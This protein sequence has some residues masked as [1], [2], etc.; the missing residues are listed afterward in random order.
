MASWIQSSCSHLV[1]VSVR[2]SGYSV[3]VLANSVF[4]SSAGMAENANTTKNNVFWR[5]TG[6]EKAFS[7]RQ[8][9]S[10]TGRTW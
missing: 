8:V 4:G 2:F 3:E 9:H 7:E 10:S 1:F 5:K 6:T